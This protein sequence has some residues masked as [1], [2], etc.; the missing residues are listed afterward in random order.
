M[1][2]ATLLAAALAGGVDGFAASG[3]T[4][5]GRSWESPGVGSGGGIVMDWGL[6]PVAQLAEIGVGTALAGTQKGLAGDVGRGSLMAG[7]GCLSRALF[8]KLAQHRE[9]TSVAVQGF[10]Q[11]PYV[12]YDNPSGRDQFGGRI[13]ADLRDGTNVPHGTPRSHYV[14]TF[15]PALIP[16]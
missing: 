8:F 2:L 7:A 11:P 10:R 16:G 14:S 1:S 4:Q 9:G 12:S 3:D 13:S 15:N 5:A 6:A